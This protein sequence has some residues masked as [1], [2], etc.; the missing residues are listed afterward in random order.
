MF[1]LH[2]HTSFSDGSDSVE[3]VIEN[4][5]NSGIDYFSITDHDTALSARTILNSEQ[6]RKK[7]SDYNMTYVTG[8]EWTC[9]FMGY[10]VHILSYDFDPFANEVFALENEIKIL[11]KEKNNFRFEHI[12]NLGYTFSQKSMEFLNSRENIRKLDLANCLVNDGY[13]SNIQ[14][15]IDRCLKNIKYPRKY[16][17]DGKKVISTLTKTGAKMVWA[18]SIHGLGKKPISYEEIDYLVSEMKKLGLAGLECYYSLYNRQEIDELIKIVKKH[19]L[20]LTCGSDYHGK[21]K[22]VA[23]AEISSDG[24]LP[25]AGEIVVDKIFKNAI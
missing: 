1:D 8:T 22:T 20:F 9:E 24:S 15:A 25:K 19:N 5:H 10:S 2:I 18:H 23:L 12:K 7:I 6:L 11:L 14:D 17:L 13:F 4:I 21:N 16:K 3:E